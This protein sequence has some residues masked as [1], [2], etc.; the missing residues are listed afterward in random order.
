MEKQAPKKKKSRKKGLT[1][2]REKFKNYILKG[3]TAEKA[4]IKAGYKCRGKNARS[5]ATRMS[6]NVSIQASIKESRENV[7]KQIEFDLVDVLTELWAVGS[8]TSKNYYDKKGNLIPPY[9]LSAEAAKAVASFEIEEYARG[10]GKLK[11]HKGSILKKVKIHNK[12]DALKDLRK[13][14]E[15]DTVKHSF[16]EKSIAKSMMEIMG[17]I[18][19]KK[20]A[21]AIW[22]KIK[23]Q[24]GITE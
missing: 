17:A 7:T 11:K 12:T 14:F 3:M 16:D 19:D 9:K 6:A 5:A 10:G 23:D 21:D 4:Y 15:G 1:D 2:R 13:H 20:V 18:P 24:L 22:D 8:S